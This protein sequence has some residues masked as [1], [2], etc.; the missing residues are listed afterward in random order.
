MRKKKKEDSPAGRHSVPGKKGGEKLDVFPRQARK[1][2]RGGRE[3]RTHQLDVIPYQARRESEVDDRGGE[4]LDVIPCQ[5]RS[6]FSWTS[7]RARQEPESMVGERRI[8]GRQEWGERWRSEEVLKAGRHSVPGK[9]RE[10]RKRE[11]TSW[12]S[13]RTRQEGGVKER[14]LGIS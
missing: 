14:I 6:G 5:A 11:D 10:R 2:E 13:F 8:P 1:E 9:R 7:F 12:T 4:K 3:E